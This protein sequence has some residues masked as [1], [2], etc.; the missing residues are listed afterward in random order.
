MKRI[1]K[2]LCPPIFVIA[3]KSIKGKPHKTRFYRPENTEKQE[4]DIYWSEDMAYQLEN[5]EK[6]IR[7]MKL[8]ACWLIVRGKFLILP[9]VQE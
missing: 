6:T 7:G 8:N 1:L 3:L 2:L 5:W 9:A 4:L